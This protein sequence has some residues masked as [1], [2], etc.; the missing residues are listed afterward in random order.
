[1][2]QPGVLSKSSGS[3]WGWLAVAILLAFAAWQSG[4]LGKLR[5]G[6]ETVNQAWFDTYSDRFLSETTVVRV[7]GKA[8]QRPFPTAQ[9]TEVTG[10]YPDGARVR[11]RWVRGAD[12][13]ILWF[14]AGEG[15]YLWEG[16]LIGDPAVIAAARKAALNTDTG[17]EAAS[18][19]ASAAASVAPAPTR[20]APAQQASAAPAAPARGFD[21]ATSAAVRRAVSDPALAQ[22][23][24]TNAEVVTP[25]DEQG[26]TRLV[27]AMCAQR[28]GFD[29]FSAVVTAG[30]GSRPRVQ[31]CIHDSRRMAGDSDWYEPGR[32]PVRR[33][34]LCPSALAGID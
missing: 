33:P 29:Y 27:W 32:A 9:G 7:N 25:P 19:T 16:P 2:N 20:A 23:I 15:V 21:A 12:P 13:K 3:R 30:T 4:L 8:N 11:G 10:F 14:K 28:C 24:I 34:G 18:E 1:M 26:G 6:P 31:V 5:G 17:S 22:E